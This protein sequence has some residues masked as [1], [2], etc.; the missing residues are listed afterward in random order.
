VQAVRYGP[1]TVECC[2]EL[3]CPFAQ[4]SG[5]TCGSSKKFLYV[6]SCCTADLLSCGVPS[7]A[8]LSQNAIEAECVPVVGGGGSQIIECTASKSTDKGIIAKL[9]VRDD[10]VAPTAVS[11]PAVF[12]HMY[13]YKYTVCLLY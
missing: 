10:T 9:A 11:S 4:V 13:E 6:I 5:Y 7:Y 8:A 1:T 3:Q 12:L 2:T